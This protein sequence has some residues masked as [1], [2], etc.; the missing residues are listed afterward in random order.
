MKN[1]E[2]LDQLLKQALSP[3]VEP[4]EDLNQKI[5]SR[6]K[7]NRMMKPTVKKRLAIAPIAAAITLAM[8]I[9]AFAAWQLLSPK[10]VAEHLGYQT[11][12]R[13]FEDKNAIE[14]NKS[15]ASGGYSFTLHGIVSGENLSDFG[16]SGQD[17]H[18]DRTYAVVSIAKQDGSKMPDTS[19]EDYGRVPFFIS[20]LIKGEKPWQVNIASMNGGYS[21]C[22]IDGVMYRLIECDGV[23]IF[24]DRGLYLCISTSNFYDVN[25]FNYNEET[26]EISPNADYKGA[27]ALFDLPLD[28]AK[29]DPARAEKYL[30]ELL[31]KP[32]EDSAAAENETEP[33]AEIQLRETE[34]SNGIV[35]PESVK[36][37]TYD[38]KGMACYEYEGHK[39]SF[40]VDSMFEEGQTG[41]SAAASIAEIDGKRTAVQFSRDADGVITGRVLKLN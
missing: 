29:A 9:T 32:A 36:E 25:A 37:V 3:T 14:I 18:P 5:I 34:L 20:P 33:G 11:L 41:L 22:V 8:S 38:E 17:I 4:G 16:G 40:A 35:I 12:A 2:Q 27:S 30:Q 26:G 15:V 13:A 6:L 24:A 31:G 10:Q 39:I 28:K 1:C 21:D 23:E 19:D 7:E